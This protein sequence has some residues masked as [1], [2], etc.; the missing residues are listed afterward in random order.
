VFAEDDLEFV[1][2]VFAEGD[3]FPVNLRGEI[4]QDGEIGGVDAQ[5]RRGQEEAWRLWRNFSSREIAFAF[6]RR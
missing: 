6:E 3:E 2:P 5:C 1:T 4:A